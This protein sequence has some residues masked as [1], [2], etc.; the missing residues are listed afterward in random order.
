MTG[1][2]R[3]YFIGC[4]MGGWHTEKGDALAVCVWDG[5]EFHHIEA[6]AG[7]FLYPIADEGVLARALSQAEEEKARIVIAIDAALGWPRKFVELVQQ[8]HEGN[9]LP[10]FHLGCSTDNPYLY[11]E[12]ERFIKN[13]VLT[14]SKERPLTAPGDK[15][16]NNCSKAQGLVAWLKK[17][18]PDVYRPP[19]DTWDAN[20]ASSKKATIVEVYPKASMKSEEFGNLPWPPHQTT[21]RSVGNSDI[22]DAKRCAM[23]GLCYAATVGMI[24]GD[25]PLVYVPSDADRETY[26]QEDIR[27]EGWIFAP[28]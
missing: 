24:Q 14:G 7:S 4:D 26:D 19:F 13:R 25:W 5:N 27:S 9:H 18:L 16:G 23:T 6:E 2:L 12:T 20:A 1:R 21:M 10:C 11:R 17:R 3:T 28:K 22:G 8:A 15:F